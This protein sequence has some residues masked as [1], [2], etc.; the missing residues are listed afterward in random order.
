MTEETNNV[1]VNTI[2]RISEMDIIPDSIRLYTVAQV[3]EILQ[4]SKTYVYRLI[5]AGILK[6]VKL[7]KLKIRHDTLASFLRRVEGLDLTDPTQIYK[8]KVA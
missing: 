5:N 8:L 6:C 2:T 4:T 1:T 7:G 3:A